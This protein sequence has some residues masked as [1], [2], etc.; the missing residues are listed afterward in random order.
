MRGG[1]EPFTGADDPRLV[2]TVDT[3]RANSL[4][5]SAT[6]RAMEMP[7]ETMKAR[8]KVAEGFGMLSEEELRSPNAPS[9]DQYLAIKERKAALFQ[10]KARKGNWDKPVLVNLPKGPFRLKLFG[11]PHLDSDACDF[12]LFEKHW[13]EMS[14]ENRVYGM[15]IGDWFNNWLRVLGHLWKHEGDPD[16][17]WLLLEYLMEERG[18]ALIAACSGN[19]DDWS[20]GPVDPV[21]ALMKRH[22]VVYRKG[23]VRVFL[24]A[25]ERPV[26]VALRHK[27]RGHSM[28]SPAHALRRAAA[29]GWGD[30]ILVGGHTHQDENRMYVDPRS[31]HI[32][33]LYQLSAFKKFDE[34]VDVHGFRPHSIQPVVDLVVQPDRADDDP[35]R[36]KC[37]WDSDDAA[38]FFASL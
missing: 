30:T 19:H 18:E 20:H 5:V 4:N 22:G 36:V 23:A 21:D 1:Q 35:D 32:S 24:N 10:A 33:H 16:D 2:E 29:E 34:Y 8:L 12:D 15:C 7:R 25:A 3:F 27:W 11:D 38:K 26:T 6:A 17:A 28:Y 9:R 37:F 31:G 13:L 14:A